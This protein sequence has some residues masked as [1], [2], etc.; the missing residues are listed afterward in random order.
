M[1]RMNHPPSP[2]K[3]FVIIGAATALIGSILGS[4]LIGVRFVQSDRAK[5][6]AKAPAAAAPTTPAPPV[7]PATRTKEQGMAALMALPELQAWSA[8]LA[9]S[10]GGKA[11]GALLE[12]DT[13]PRDW[14]GKRYW[15]LSFVENDAD[16]VQRWESF[17]VSTSDDEILVDDADS[18]QPLTLERWRKE[19]HPERR[20]SAGG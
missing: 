16:A 9:K 11:H 6:A 14:K 3:K 7:A 2:L 13:A 1:Q 15:Q 18:D 10:S 20:T 5:A 8:G 19:K 4:Y 12:Y 17:L